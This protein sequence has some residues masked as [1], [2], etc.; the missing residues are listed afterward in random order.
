MKKMFESMQNWLRS[1]MSSETRHVVR[2]CVD[3][4]ETGFNLFLGLFLKKGRVKLTRPC[5]VLGSS[6][7]PHPV[8]MENFDLICVNCSGYIAKDWGLPDPKV[9]LLGAFKLVVPKNEVDRRVLKG[10][11]TETLV[12]IRHRL[13]VSKALATVLL[14]ML[15]YRY[16]EF[17]RLGFWDR[18]Y[19]IT[20]VVGK[21][22]P[23]SNGVFAVCY[24][25]YN[26]APEVVLVGFSLTKDGHYY[27]DQ[28]RPRGHIPADLEALI[29]ICERGWN[30]KTSEPELSEL[31]GIPLV[32]DVDGSKE[33]Q[34]LS[35]VNVF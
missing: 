30:I 34:V 10:L 28:N 12:F 19:M 8:H 32:Q 24:A 5:M 7:D 23:V 13:P 26:G 20:K 16:T 9:T 4:I 21:R 14:D 27:P 6:P 15:E 35:E 1:H 33:V 18:A 11:R 2:Y 3:S 25:L 29:A 17:L 22:L 31:T